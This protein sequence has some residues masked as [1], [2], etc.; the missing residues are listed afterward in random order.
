MTQYYSYIRAT[1]AVE[2]K[3]KI[4]A[5]GKKTSSNSGAKPGAKIWLMNSDQ[6]N[7][8]KHS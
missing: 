2:Q 8:G 6:L 5:F 7:L 3:L 4:D 1:P